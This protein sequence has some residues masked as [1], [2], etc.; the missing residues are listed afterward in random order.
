VAIDK[1]LPL[2]LEDPAS[3]GTETDEFPTSLDPSEDHVQC[4]GIVLGDATHSDESTRVWRDGDDLKFKDANN[5][6]DVT[7]SDLLT[8]T[9]HQDLDTITHWI[10][11][12]SYDEIVRTGGKVTSIVVWNSVLKTIKIREELITRVS[13]KVSQIVTNQYDRSTG[14]LKE[15]LTEIYTR[16]GDKVTSIARTRVP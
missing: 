1:V 9:R 8:E 4:A 3:G 13:G 7:L 2:K 6:V 14:V 10:D 16:T 12:N 5:P 11:E 15:T